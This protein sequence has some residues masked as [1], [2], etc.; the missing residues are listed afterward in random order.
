[1]TTLGEFS[2]GLALP[3]N[4]YEEGVLAKMSTP[5][6]RRNIMTRREKHTQIDEVYGNKLT[7]SEKKE[8]LDRLYPEG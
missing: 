5:G 3:D 4:S 1:M 7:P 6:L 8:L 2:R